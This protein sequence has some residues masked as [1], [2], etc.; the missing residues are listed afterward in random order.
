MLQW[1]GWG[2]TGT[3]VKLRV[4]TSVREDDGSQLV[5]TPATVCENPAYAELKMLYVPTGSG[6]VSVALTTCR[7]HKAHAVRAILHCSA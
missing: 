4:G 7:D 2:L 3:T 1:L 5:V 6:V